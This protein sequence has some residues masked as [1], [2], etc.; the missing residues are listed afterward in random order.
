M[1]AL[2]LLQRIP[3]EFS[4]WYPR[5]AW[6]EKRRE[7]VREGLAMM[8]RWNMDMRRSSFRP[9]TDVCA[10][11]PGGGGGELA[12]GV[13]EAESVEANPVHARKVTK[14]GKEVLLEM[15]AVCTLLCIMPTA[16]LWACARHVMYSTF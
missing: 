3:H 15:V 14:M 13:K 6:R 9:R 5:R 8:V 1:H 7:V 4:R 11:G 10:N 12:R 16:I 2:L